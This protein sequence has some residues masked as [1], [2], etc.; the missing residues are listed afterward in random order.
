MTEK[1]T[2][3]DIASYIVPG[4]VML[5]LVYWLLVGFFGAAVALPGEDIGQSILLIL[6]SYLLGHLLQGI[7]IVLQSKIMGRWGGNFTERFMRD[8]D[9]NYP[10]EFKKAIRDGATEVL[11]LN[12][13]ATFGTETGVNNRKQVFELCRILLVQ[14]KASSQIE[15]LDGLF[16]LYRSMIPVAWLG[17]VV[18]T[19]IT[20]KHLFLTTKFS[21][22]A[23]PQVGFLHY[24][25]TQLLL[26][27]V[28]MIFFIASV[29]FMESRLKRA[30]RH[31]VHLVYRN[32][33]VWCR[34]R[35]LKSTDGATTTGTQP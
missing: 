4:A 19:V 8:S 14:E 22:L 18:S 13:D 15:F 11:G 21:W 17:L 9:S 5:I 34:R 30:S 23:S 27:S 29:P 6:V 25:S 26:G 28:S 10:S 31:Y 3:Y 7:A 33:Y 35:Y 24:D 1:F 16:A 32:F 20:T 12:I 2:F